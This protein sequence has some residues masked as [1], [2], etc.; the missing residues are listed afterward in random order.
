MLTVPEA[1]E[2]IINRSRYLSEA[3]SK[4]LINLSA[5]ARY[6]KPELEEMLNKKVSDT[7][8]FM[9]L[10]RLSATIKP[11]YVFKNIFKSPPDMIVRSNLIGL[12]IAHSEKLADRYLSILKLSDT[13]DKHFLTVTQGTFN[14]TIITSKDLVNS[15]KN[16]LKDEIIVTEFTN[17]SSI[18]IK[19][20]KEA[21][22][23]PGIFYFFLKS[24]AWEGVNIVEIVSSYLE[25]T[26][27]LPEKET[28]RAFSI[29]QSLFVLPV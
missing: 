18:T 5:L 21:V 17:L 27:I 20:P 13:N 8:I 7:A 12:T 22:S 9:A 1:A 16:I 6:M 24:L 3:I 28:N 25:F 11:R 4:G 10:N 26:L 23:T 2:K 19:L 14:A 29:I 15:I